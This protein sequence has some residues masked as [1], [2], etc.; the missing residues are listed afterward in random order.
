MKYINFHTD[1]PQFWS[2]LRTS[3]LSGTFC[4]VHVNYYTFFY[5]RDKGRGGCNNYAENIRRYILYYIIC[6]IIFIVLYYIILHLMYRII[7]YHYILYLLYYIILYYIILFYIILYYTSR[8]TR[9]CPGWPMAKPDSKFVYYITKKE[10][11][12]NCGNLSEWHMS[13]VTYERVQYLRKST[14]VQ[15]EGSIVNELNVF[16]D[17]E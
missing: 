9:R 16:F 8:G 5:M 10:D 2:E 1:G 7:L 12:I 6:Y 11:G 3:P 15:E 4:S 17:N 14:H 13:H